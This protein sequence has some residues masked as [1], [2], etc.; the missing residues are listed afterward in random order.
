MLPIGDPVAGGGGVLTWGDARRV[1]YQRDQVAFSPD[2]E[3]QHAKATIGVVKRDSLDEA[4][5]LLQRGKNRRR[6]HVPV[7]SMPDPS[8]RALRAALPSIPRQYDPSA[9]VL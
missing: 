5:E 9:K 7:Q 2:L 3:P 4:A 6:G 8:G 1:T